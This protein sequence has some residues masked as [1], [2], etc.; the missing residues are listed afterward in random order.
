MA[1]DL[2]NG[3]PT[4]LFG[5]GDVGMG[6][7]KNVNNQTIGV[8]FALVEKGEVNRDINYKPDIDEIMFRILSIKPDGL[9]SIIKILTQVRDE[10]MVDCGC[11][12]WKVEKN[13]E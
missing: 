6:V 10:M 11:A 5:D 2:Y 12:C 7:I 9:N 3:V 8:H 4:L 1:F 13:H